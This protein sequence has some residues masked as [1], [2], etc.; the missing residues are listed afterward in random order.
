[1]T[2]RYELIVVGAG[3]CGIAVGAAAKQK[4]V[5]CV[6]FDKGC[7]TSSLVSYPYY[8]TFF[9]TAVMLEIGG[10]PFTIPN[11]KP[12]R[13]E[14]L[15]YYRRVVDHWDL[16]VRQY[17]E[18]VRV[19]G[20]EGAYEVLTRSRGGDEATQRAD[21]VVIATGGFHEPNWLGVP[22]EDLP[23]VRH[24]YHEP[25]PY[26]D[27]DVLVVGAGNSAVEAALEMYR[28]G[29][30]VTMVHFLDQIDRGV[31][32]WVVPDITN[33]LAKG[34]I[35]VFW[36]HRVAEIRLDSVVLRP[37]HGS[38]ETELPNDFVVAMTGWRAD[39]RPLRELGVD[40]DDA[41]GIPAH[42]PETMETNVP[43]LYIAGVIAAGYDA[44]KI[45]IENGREHGD[46]IV[47]D[48]LAR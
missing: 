29:V 45:F 32:P 19:T 36:R 18:V 24:H 13:R 7:V 11:P 43:G 8:M 9:S 10:V 2:D 34:E 27:Q 30:R 5:S 6:L 12:T 3:P 42:D 37:E 40:I 16:D 47:R 26:F 46:L 21:A 35:P 28:N 25:Y 4:G 14:A 31:K 33:R 23:K 22:G 48:R 17:E 38:G 44:N 15:A 41:T 1:M 39:H 20:Q